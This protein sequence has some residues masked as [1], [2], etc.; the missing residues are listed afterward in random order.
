MVFVL[1]R[2]LCLTTHWPIPQ[3]LKSLQLSVQGSVSEYSL[4]GE[5]RLLDEQSREWKEDVHD[6]GECRNLINQMLSIFWAPAQA[7][8]LR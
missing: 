1:Y 8:S 5:W 2:V 7:H 6:Y 3:V 4:Q